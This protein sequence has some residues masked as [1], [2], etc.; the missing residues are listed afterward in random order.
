MFCLWNLEE[1]IMGSREAIDK[2]NKDAIEI[3]KDPI[4]LEKQLVIETSI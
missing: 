4:I 3:L 1:V 2:M